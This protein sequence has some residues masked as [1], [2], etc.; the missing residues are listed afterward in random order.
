[1]A[2]PLRVEFPGALYL[3]TAR[4]IPR[5][6]LFRDDEETADFI[7]RLP[8]LVESFGVVI[9]G[10]CL[11]PNHYHLLLET[12]RANLTRALHLLN[13]G[14]TAAVNAGR[15][16]KGP[17]LQTRYRSILLEEDPWLLRL[18]VHVHLNPVRKKLARDPWSYPASSASAFASGGAAIPGLTTDRV[19]ARAGGRESYAALVQEALR[20]PSPGPWKEVWRQAV[21][22]G[23]ALRSRVLSV[24]EGADTREIAGFT[25]DRGGVE[26][27][28][29]VG[30]VSENTGVASREI[31][32]SKFQRVLA[33]K[34]AIHL[35][36]RF[37]GLTLRQI[38]EYFG[39]DYTTIHMASRRVEELR[40]EDP[41]VDELVKALEV[42]L[43]A[44]GGEALPDAPA[45]EEP[46]PAQ[47]PSRKKPEEKAPKKETPQ[48]K[49]F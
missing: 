8:R 40:R 11:L 29:V 2:R 21:L 14:Y 1:M 24:L 32:R 45:A 46:K 9:H 38:G 34:L 31:L 37:T 18:S 22:G 33:R 26:L 5:Q 41:G 6:K 25:P 47:K 12:P 16:R 49:L 30:L 7:A 42:E 19:L 43:S 44:G 28:R 3:V 10:F 27:D 13:S 17:L 39:V 23:E 20:K 35:A 15:G 48:L 4:A 36:R